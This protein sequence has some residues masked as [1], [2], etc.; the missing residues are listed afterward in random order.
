MATNQPQNLSEWQLHC[1][2][3]RAS[4]IQYYDSFINNGEVDV[5]KLAES[6]DIVFKDIME[7][8]GMAKKP[9]HV[10][11]FRNTLL[12]WTKDP[13]KNE[14]VPS[15]IQKADDAKSATAVQSLKSTEVSDNNPQLPRRQN[16]DDAKQKRQDENCTI[17]KSENTEIQPQQDTK[18][19]QTQ[20]VVK[21]DQKQHGLFPYYDELINQTVLDKMVLDN[22]ISRCILMI[23]DREEIIKPTTQRERNRVLLNILTKRPYGTTEVLKDVLQESNQYNNDVLEIVSKMQCSDSCDEPFSCHD[24]MIHEHIVKLHKNYLMFVNDMDFRTDI[25]DHLYETGVLDSEEKEEVYNFSI[26]RHESNRLLLSKLVRKGEDAYVKLLEALKHGGNEDVVSDIE[27]T[28]VSDL[29]IQ[30]CQIGIKQLRDREKKK[31]VRVTKIEVLSP[32][33][34]EEVIPKHI[35]DQFERRLNQ[36]KVDDEQF[37]NITAEK[38]VMEHIL[39]E[40]T[41]TIVGNSGTGKTFLSRHVA[42]TMMKQGY[43]IIPCDNPGDI[44]QWFKPGRKTLFVFDDVCGRYILNQQIYNDWKQ[45][46]DHITSLLKDKCCKIMVTSRLDVY[47]N[48]QFG[49]LSI[50]KTC[51]IDLSSEE[52]K[53]NAAEKLNLAKVYFKDKASKVTELSEKY[54]F[55]PLLC[56]LYHKQQSQK[57]VN[58]SDFFSNPFDIFRNELNDWYS[59]GKAG[60]VKYCSLVLCVMFNNTLSEENFNTKNSKIGTVLGDLFEE[61]ELNKGTPIKR[62]Q[63]SLET[64]EGTYVVKEGSIYKIIHDKL[65]D[66]LSSY[67]GKNMLQL[68]IDHASPE[69]ISE[70]FL[71]KA[72]DNMDT[73]KDFAIG[74][75]DSF[76]NAYIDRLIKDWENGFV[77]NVFTNKNMNSLKFTETFMSCINKID[78]S[79]QEALASIEDTDFNYTALIINCLSGV[80]NLVEWLISRKSVINHC[81]EYGIS[82]LHSAC[83][84]GDVD[85]VKKLIQHAADVN[86]CDNYGESPLYIASLEGHADVVKELIQHSADVNQCDNDGESPLYIASQEGHVDVVKEL[87][88]HSPD[89]NKCSNDGVSPLS[90][91]SSFNKTEVVK[92]LLPCDEVDINLCDKDGRSSLYWASQ[93]GHV[94]VVKELLQHSAEINQSRISGS[95]P[96]LVASQQGY[97]DVVTELLQY[98]PDVNLCMNNGTSPLLVASG[99][100]HVN[101]VRLLLQHS[102]DVN[103]CSNIGTSPLWL[104]SKE[105]QLDVV[106]ELLLHSVEINQSRNSGSSPLLVASQQGYFD[107]VTELLQHSPDVNLCMNNGTSPL[108]V[109]SGKGHVNI[110]KLLLQHASDVN[111]C[112]NTG[113]SP[114]WLASKEG[115]LDVVKVLLQHSADV[116][117]CDIK[118]RSPLN[119]AREHGHNEIESF[120]RKTNIN[121][122]TKDSL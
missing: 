80:G 72:V 1:V 57:D 27:K 56:S 23:E 46:L 91:A 6:D 108:L 122:T 83:D 87:L 74:I 54:E 38:K 103:L 16:D 79:K 86:Q 20:R 69:F 39:K 59:E 19:K 82:P 53:L 107:V 121:F 90:R 61:C 37:V 14:H 50:F 95:S 3:K 52:F 41:V 45:R 109:A 30:W 114:L 32:D 89:V 35:L 10:R 93:Q 105:G 102:S 63:K 33:E 26:T 115:Q 17:Y 15:Y 120:L 110:V 47:K 81:G 119:V 29:E 117:K 85:I 11:Q 111:L 49:K 94:D 31:D 76:I 13:G 44:R 65:F 112:T 36:W 8:V 5:I 64:F 40:S 97:F 24:I 4:L 25:S 12:E 42:L 58:L 98:S 84:N 71:W 60:K 75:P 113:V 21:D 55:F 92:V 78:Q 88:Q 2:L 96:L 73:D 99:K 18:S 9:L 22:L 106:K 101:I 62:L 28:A 7:K 100:G 43:I 67:F 104:A 66:F 70:R 68:F 51:S 48:E 34:P 116:Y 118:G 77:F